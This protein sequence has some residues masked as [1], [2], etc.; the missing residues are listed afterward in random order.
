MQIEKELWQR[1][2]TGD[3]QAYA[4]VF[5][6]LYRK[7]YNYGK[8]FTGGDEFLE[9]AIQET[10]LLV[11]T[12]RSSLSS[13]EYPATYFFSS[14]RYTLL[15][16]LKRNRP[17]S[18]ETQN[19]EAEFAADHFILQ[20]ETDAEGRLQL[21]KALG[22]LTSRQREAVFLRFYEGMSYEEV[23]GSLGIT[24]KATYKLVARALEELRQRLNVTG[25][26]LLFLLFGLRS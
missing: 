24:V 2:A 11:W 1:T 26:F 5:R 4:A 20:K 25:G 7:L 16:K 17:F 15:G 3:Q 13:L 6:T 23:A 10:L 22:A 9:D 19:D 21:A 14:F 12:K 18:G 8:K